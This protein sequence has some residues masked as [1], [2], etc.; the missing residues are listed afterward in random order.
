MEGGMNVGNIL[1]ITLGGCGLC[2]VGLFLIFGLQIVAIFIE[3]F[4]SLF[5]L[6]ASI[7]GIGPFG[8][9]GCLFFLGVL[10]AC[11]GI[12]VFI[13][14]QFTHCGTELATNFCSLIGQ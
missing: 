8:G 14:S 9:C 13:T 4:S 12:V 7:V 5:E 10:L 6:F 2:V 11:A 3:G 1:L